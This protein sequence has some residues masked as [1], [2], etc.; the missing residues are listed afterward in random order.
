MPLDDEKRAPVAWTQLAQ[1]PIGRLVVEMRKWHPACAGQRR[2]LDDAVVNQRIVNDH[3]VSTEQMPDHRNVGRMAPDK[4]GAILAAM[5]PC[6]HLLEL[7]VKRPFAGDR[8]TR[9]DRGPITVNRILGCVGD[10]GMTVEP[11]VIVGSEVD[12]SVIADH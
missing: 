9:R 2:S 5:Y 1:Q 10:M 8:A 6:E 7:A 3:V 11:E 12:V 4:N